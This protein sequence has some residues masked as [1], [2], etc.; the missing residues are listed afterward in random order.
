MRSQQ[1]RRIRGGASTVESSLSR[2][3]ECLDSLSCALPTVDPIMGMHT[4]SRLR[5]RYDLHRR[6]RYRSI[7][8]PGPGPGPGRCMT[9]W[10]Q[11]GA[12]A[13]AACGTEP[14][15]LPSPTW[16]VPLLWGLLD[17]LFA[18]YSIIFVTRQL[19]CPLYL[20]PVHRLPVSAKQHP[21]PH[22]HPPYTEGSTGRS[23]A[24]YTHM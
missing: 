1:A 21:R 17:L 14:V 3:E 2:H 10:G 5:S 9:R 23:I 12:G 15:D 22:Q 13:C 7:P 6:H 16:R 8:M 11:G 18:L 4:W 20:S 19:E 24:R